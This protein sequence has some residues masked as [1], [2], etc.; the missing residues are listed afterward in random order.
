MELLTILMLGAIGYL[1]YELLN[2]KNIRGYK[3]IIWR[4]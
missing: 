2:K 3:D 4:R 1:S